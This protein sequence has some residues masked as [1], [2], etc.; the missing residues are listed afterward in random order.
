MTPSGTAMQ[1]A[2]ESGSSYPVSYGVAG[3]AQVAAGQ[4]ST[5]AASIGSSADK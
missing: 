2:I 4:E 1:S 3:A 5:D